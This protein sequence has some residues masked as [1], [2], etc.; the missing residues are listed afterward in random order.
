MAD[1]TQTA[2]QAKF[3]WTTSP[4]QYHPPTTRL[5]LWEQQ[6]CAT[7]TPKLTWS[8]HE[9]ALA[10]AGILHPFQEEDSGGQVGFQDLWTAL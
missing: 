3:I 9:L 6:A 8:V 1:W 5:C 10:Q 2:T 4:R 7:C